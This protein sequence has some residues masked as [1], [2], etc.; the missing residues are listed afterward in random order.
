[1]I[2]VTH[3]LGTGHLA[4]ALTLGRAFAAQGDTVMVVS[5]GTPVPHFDTQGLSLVQLP[6]VHSN[7][8]DFTTLLTQQGTPASPVDMQARGDQL[9]ASLAAFAPDVLITEL[10]P[11]G[12][13]IL[14][15][16]FRA[17]LET[18]RTL[19]QR[20]L[21]LASIR[22]ILAPPSKPAKAAFADDMISRFYDGVLVHSD[23]DIVPLSR[24]WPVSDTLGPYLHYTGF[25]APPAPGHV[26]QSHGEI[27]V[28][29]G[30]G[31]VGDAVFK[32]ASDAA[33]AMP[34]TLWRFVVGGADARVAH[35]SASAPPNVTVEGLRPDFRDLLGGAAASVSMC[36][37]NTALDILQTGVR[38]V[39]IPFDDGGEVE[40]GLRAD[41][42]ASQPGI[43]MLTQD[44]LSG[45]ALAQAL[46]RVMNAPARPPRTSGMDGATQTVQI[47]HALAQGHAA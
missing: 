32:A 37:Y 15:D 39:L 4:R 11:F 38:A 23:P 41:A 21:T 46:T 16:E 26:V 28:S 36:G 31:S 10:F 27:L 40:Q 42:L 20:P 13:R 43:A 6:P 33:R 5:G 8:T 17:V 45:G 47:V 9:L 18:A 44:A 35:L 22:D 24:S 12:R 30:G 34:E 7:G 14:R 3:L 1:M 19:P 29:T 25:V 2:V